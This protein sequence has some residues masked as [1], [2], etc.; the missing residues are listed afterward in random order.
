[1]DLARN[2]RFLPYRHLEILREIGSGVVIWTD[3]D[4]LD[5]KGLAAAAEVHSHIAA[6]RPGILQLNNPAAS[7]PRF[8]LLRRLYD[9][10]V[11]S[12]NVFRLSEAANVERFPVF[13][14]RESGV[15]K[16]APSLC[17]DPSELASALTSIRL[18]DKE[19]ADLMIVEFRNV[20]GPDGYF[21]K[22]GAYCVGD[23]IYPQHI[24]FSPNWFVKHPISTGNTQRL[25]AH[26]AYVDTNPHGSALKEI[27]KIACIEYG[28]IDY[29]LVDD[30]IEVFEIN[31]NPSVINDPPTIFDGREN[32]A[33]AD[34]H[35][36]AFL[37]LEGATIEEDPASADEYAIKR[38]HEETLNT[39]RR[40]FTRR[41]A[42]RTVRL[43]FARFI[44]G[45]RR[46]ATSSGLR[47]S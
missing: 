31:T 45:F 5:D 29:C 39:L 46:V 32:Q 17:N 33:Y 41:R 23:H 22:Y 36:A 3:F 21:R 7:L 12:F 30:R 24:F 15:S 37:R 1:M 34:R 28:R 18:S 40:K 4:R 10:G 47:P 42:K 27:F 19:C 20:A 9:A 26:Q 43:A 14:R 16:V 13:I 11:N 25:A 8:T 6:T 2:V 35:A 38:I 44:R